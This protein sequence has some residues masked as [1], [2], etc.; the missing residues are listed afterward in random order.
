[1]GTTGGGVDELAC[2]ASPALLALPLNFSELHA[3]T[4]RAAHTSKDLVILVFIL[5]NE[6]QEIGLRQPTEFG[7]L[8]SH[9][10]GDTSDNLTIF[11]TNSSLS[12][13]V[14][15]PDQLTAFDPPLKERTQSNFHRS[16]DHG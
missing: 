2:G 1:M 13:P 6:M 15:L 16:D 12:R 4:A 10:D 5:V 8:F 9:F 7:E 3:D 14:N 11:L